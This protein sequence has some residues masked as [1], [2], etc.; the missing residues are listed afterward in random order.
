MPSAPRITGVLG[1]GPAA[2]AGLPVGALITKLDD[3]SIGSGDA[4]IAAV[5]SKEPGTTVTSRSPTLW[6]CP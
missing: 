5:Q 6:A 3:Q 2:A 4:L 1:G